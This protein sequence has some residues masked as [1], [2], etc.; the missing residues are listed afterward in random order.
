MGISITNTMRTMPRRRRPRRWASMDNT[1]SFWM[2][3]PTLVN[4]LTALGFTSVS[5]VLAPAMPGNLSD[6]KTYLAVKGR[7]VSIL[8]SEPT[9]A[10]LRPLLEEGENRRMD[11][12]QTPRGAV[13]KLAKRVLP[14]GLKDAIKPPLR[15][16]G[17]L[18]PDPT[19]EFM[20]KKR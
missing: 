9:D 1:A 13:F 20:K 2:T 18:P 10:M 16:I 17:L 11:A 7:P 4:S 6:R 5:D 12:S 8:S 14:P 19:P 3:E 15:L